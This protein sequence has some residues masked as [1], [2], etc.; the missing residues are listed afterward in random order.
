[1]IDLILGTAG[2]I[3]HG[4]T[5]LVRALTG[6]NT[7]RLPEEQ[8]RGITIDL[9]FA[10]LALAPY[11]LGIVDVPGHERFVRNMLAGASGV[12]LALLV[13]AADDSIKP[14]TREHLEIL[15]LLGLEHGVIALTKCDLVDSD[16][17]QLVEDEVRELVAGSFLAHAP[18]IRTSALQEKGL[19]ALRDALRAAAAQAAAAER[20]RRI[21]EP[22]R[23]AIDRSFT[24]AGHGTVV[25]GSIASG[26]VRVGDV[27][28]IEPG[29][30]SVRVREI[31]NHD[32]SVEDAHRGQRAAINLAGIHHTE[33]RRGQELA[34]PGHL[35][36]SRLLTAQVSLLD[37]APRPL[38][39]RDRVRIHLG[40]AELT[41]SVA[42]LDAEHIPPGQAALV[43]LFFRDAV[44]AVWGQPFVVRSESPAATIGGGRVLDPVAQKIRTKEAATFAANLTSGE[45]MRRA[46]AAWFLAGLRNMRPEELSRNAGVS[47]IAAT[48]Q[49]LFAAG[50]LR[51]LRLSPTRNL[52]V[53]RRAW[54]LLQ[55][56]ILVA[57]AKMH[58]RDPLR[59]TFDRSQLASRFSYLD[60]PGLFD[61][62][63]RGLIQQ[64]QVRELGDRIG[65]AG[66]GPKLSKNEQKLLDQLIELYRQTGFPPPGLPECH[67]LTSKNPKIIPQLL[68][69]AAA[70]GVLVEIT[71]HMYLHESVDRE[72]RDKLAARLGGGAGVTAAEIRDILGG[73]RKHCIPYCEYLDRIGFTRREGDLRYLAQT[74]PDAA[75]ASNPVAS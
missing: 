7:D 66:R 69:V 22:F 68:S 31:Q 5:A 4:K 37:S 45:P 3:D 59:S 30:V 50:E 49:A 70:D 2:H 60:P 23:M 12:D 57:L 27:L 72:L 15:R 8:R 48:Q 29:G 47:D 43:Q 51:E 42:L 19:D 54:E 40:T 21:S 24:L 9:G 34:A 75:S 55:E 65:L 14:Q 17:L 36:P 53:H 13:V 26:V 10:E 62:A 67:A 52:I 35:Q 25:T 64:G 6:V 11:R 28:T 73:T 1:M 56:R 61:A 44:A 63:M 46:A 20:M 16:W 32:R 38:K 33:V 39:N 41:A 71:S 18:I 74:S 58:D